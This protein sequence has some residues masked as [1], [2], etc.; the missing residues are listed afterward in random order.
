MASPR[1]EVKGL[2][3]AAIRRDPGPLVVDLPVAGAAT[4]GPPGQNLDRIAPHPL[5]RAPR[6][7]GELAELRINAAERPV[8]RLI[9]K[10]RPRPCRP[11]RTFLANHVRDSATWS[12]R[13]DLTVEGRLPEVL[14]KTLLRRDAGQKS[15]T[16]ARTPT[17]KN[18]AWSVPFS[19]QAPIAME[20]PGEQKSFDSNPRARRWLPIRWRRRSCGVML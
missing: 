5:R 16:N 1:S 3:R 18:R 12:A 2:G 6:L 15:N 4:V 13:S 14:A 7:P 17:E 8:S 19:R 11:W 20:C 10:Q 9:P